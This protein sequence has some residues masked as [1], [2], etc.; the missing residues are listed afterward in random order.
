MNSD[1]HTILDGQAIDLHV[2]SVAMVHLVLGLLQVVG[3]IEMNRQR[4]E[5]VRES[6][7]VIECL[8]CEAKRNICLQDL[9][10]KLLRV[11]RLDLESFVQAHNLLPDVF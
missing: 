11:S 1:A 9:L 10:L 4:I 7:T 8:G 2:V 6:R 5:L 3:W